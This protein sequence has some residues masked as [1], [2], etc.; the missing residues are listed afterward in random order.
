[1]RTDESL[2]SQSSDVCRALELELDEA[3]APRFFRVRRVRVEGEFCTITADPDNSESALDDNLEGC[4]AQWPGG[5]ASILSVV[6]D[7]DE[8]NL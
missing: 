7:R 3:R 8:I 5:Q 2:R 6:P 4:K 1:M